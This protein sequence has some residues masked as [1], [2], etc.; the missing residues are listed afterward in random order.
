MNCWLIRLVRTTHHFTIFNVNDTVKCLSHIIFIPRR[1]KSHNDRPRRADKVQGARDTSP[2]RTRF[3]KLQLC[4]RRFERT[5]MASSSASISVVTDEIGVLMYRES[6]VWN[7]SVHALF[8][9]S[10]VDVCSTK[11]F[12]KNETVAVGKDGNH[13]RHKY[14]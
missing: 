13:L 14:H 10:M 11:H 9:F 8:M 3:D 6:I 5:L 1:T 2:E 4:L 7:K 12:P